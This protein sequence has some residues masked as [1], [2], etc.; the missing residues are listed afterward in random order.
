MITPDDEGGYV[1][2]DKKVAKELA[3]PTQ[4][5]YTSDWTFY[6]IEDEMWDAAWEL[7]DKQKAIE[8]YNRAMKGI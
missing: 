1:V 6:I 2:T 3:N 7:S 4:K 5:T 8:D